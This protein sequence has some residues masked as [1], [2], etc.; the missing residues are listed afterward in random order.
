MPLPVKGVQP[1]SHIPVPGKHK[2]DLIGK[3][4]KQE[5]KHVDVNGKEAWENKTS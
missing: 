1:L 5:P 3:P 4:K 2:L